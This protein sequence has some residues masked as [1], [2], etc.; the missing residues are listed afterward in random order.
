M[1]YALNSGGNELENSPGLFVI[2]REQIDFGYE[3]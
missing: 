1:Q 3:I 2:S